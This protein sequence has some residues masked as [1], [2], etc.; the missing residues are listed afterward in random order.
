[1]TRPNEFI[2]YMAKM[3][4]MPSFY[5]EF[6]IREKKFLDNKAAKNNIRK[7]SFINHVDKILTIFDH[8]P[9]SSGRPW[10]YQ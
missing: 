1:M 2:I 10:T 4:S 9:P 7:G 3:S 8:P 6:D 5:I